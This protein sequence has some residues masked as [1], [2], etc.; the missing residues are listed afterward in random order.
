MDNRTV[1]T[2][3]IAIAVLFV[4][5]FAGAAVAVGIYFAT[6]RKTPGFPFEREFAL[7]VQAGRGELDEATTKELQAAR[8]PLLFQISD[9]NTKPLIELF[10]QLPDD[11][12]AELQQQGYLK[13]RYAD[14]P[15]GMQAAYRNAVKTNL[16]TAKQLGQPADPTTS[17]EAL[18]TAEVGFAVI[19]IDPS[20]RVVSWYI[21]F[22][23]RPLPIWVTVVGGSAAGTPKYFQAHNSSLPLLRAKPN[24]TLP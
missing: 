19:S 4:L 10:G 7:S 5:L 13:W 1:I 17:L 22:P 3:V 2:I 6:I 11:S 18:E 12:H 15:A 14:L 8:H 23:N 9:P 16:D 24:S 20:S 21:I